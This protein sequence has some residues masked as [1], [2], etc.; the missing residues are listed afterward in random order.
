MKKI[1]A[2][3]K[4]L[5][6]EYMWLNQ[7]LAVRKLMDNVVYRELDEMNTLLLN[8]DE[9]LYD[10]IFG[11]H[12]NVNDM[13]QENIDHLQQYIQ[14]KNT[15]DIMRQKEMYKQGVRDYIQLVSTLNIGENDD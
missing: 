2:K 13:K 8:Q 9:F 3:K 4:E 14:N 5:M 10:L 15:M 11:E 12:V 1:K 7:D 6:K